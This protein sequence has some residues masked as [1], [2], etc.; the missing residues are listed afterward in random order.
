MSVLE[1]MAKSKETNYDTAL[2][3]KRKWRLMPGLAQIYSAKSPLTHSSRPYMIMQ[4]ETDMWSFE[5]L[6]TGQNLPQQ[7]KG[8]LFK[9]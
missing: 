7:T 9:R 3:I 2:L 6:L 8:H 4:P 5:N 1:N